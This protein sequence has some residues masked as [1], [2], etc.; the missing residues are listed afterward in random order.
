MHH[1]RVS[2]PDPALRDQPATDAGAASAP[3]CWLHEQRTTDIDEL[4]RAQP[5]WRLHYEQLSAGGFAGA[6]RQLQLPGV[7]LIVERLNRAVRQV[8]Q[9][10]ERGIGFAMGIEPPGPAYFHGQR[11]DRE[12]IMIGRGDELDL[13]TP[14][15]WLLIGIVVDEALLR[16]LWQQLYQKSWS[17]W[18]DRKLVVQAR[19]GSA[20][21]VRVAHFAALDAVAAHPALLADALAL[22]QLRDAVLIEWIGAI[23]AQVD[24]VGLEGIDA[25]RRLVERACRIVAERPDSAPTILELCREIGAGP[26]KLEHCFAEVLGMS[27]AK[28]LR[29]IRL[30]GVRR[31][32]KRQA[33]PQAP[34]ADLA[35]RW[36]FWHQGAFAADYK[37]QFGELPS[38]T[39]RGS[40]AAD[41]SG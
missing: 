34:V 15:G 23:P 5:D 27:P 8:G 25:R 33:Q 10:G 18:L 24:A 22:R 36:G 3:G 20:E 19:A 2:T 41:S 31:E 17:A 30:N 13:T 7:R 21:A 16:E 9:I 26:R 6:L 35:A 28:Y 37:R 38:V 32:L 4:A 12:S 39:A 1:R 14:E 40:R 29:A 11:L